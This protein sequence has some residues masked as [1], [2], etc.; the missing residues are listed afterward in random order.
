MFR[1]ENMAFYGHGADPGDFFEQ[2]FCYNRGTHA[3]VVLL[4][5]Q[6][7]LYRMILLKQHSLLHYDF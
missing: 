1:P 4:L 7:S 3:C 6:I 5:S 2:M